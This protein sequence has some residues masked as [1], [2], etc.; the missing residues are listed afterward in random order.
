M[1]DMDLWLKVQNTAY[2]QTNESKIHIIL[3]SFALHI[4]V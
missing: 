3:N 4:Y 2:V 1:E